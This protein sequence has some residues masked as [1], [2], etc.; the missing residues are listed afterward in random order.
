MYNDQAIKKDISASE[1][2]IIL[3]SYPLIQ[4]ILNPVSAMIIP[5]IGVKRSICNGMLVVAATTITF[6]FIDMMIPSGTPFFLVALSLRVIA[7]IGASLTNIA[8]LTLTTT[9]FS[10][11]STFVF[12][13][14]SILVS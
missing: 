13:S 10:A 7:A 5:K 4:M 3:G 6:S 9:Y 12:V 8:L 14:I 1:F 2:G 11:K